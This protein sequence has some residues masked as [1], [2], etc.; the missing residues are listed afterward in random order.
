MAVLEVIIP[1][2][3]DDVE[4]SVVNQNLI[5]RGDEHEAFM[6][7]DPAQAPL[8]PTSLPTDCPIVPAND[9]L[10][11]STVKVDKIHS[12]VA[13]SLERRSDYGG[14]KDCR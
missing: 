5:A 2:R 13:L 6:K 4:V 10:T 9:F 8:R 7:G 3:I 12:S 14:S 11:I 1:E